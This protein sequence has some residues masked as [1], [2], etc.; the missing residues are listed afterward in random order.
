MSVTIP[1]YPDAA[2]SQMCRPITKAL[3]R[4]DPKLAVE[5]FLSA[6]KFYHPIARGQLRKVC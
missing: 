6:E 2:I 1:A 3:F 5:T 4:V